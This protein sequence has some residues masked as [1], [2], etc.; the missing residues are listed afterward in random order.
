MDHKT[1]P[2][3]AE[4]VIDTV[5]KPLDIRLGGITRH[6]DELNKP[7]EKDAADQ[8]L[9][10]R[11][12]RI[13]GLPE[14]DEEHMKDTLVKLFKNRL[15]ITGIKRSDIRNVHWIGGKRTS[16]RRLIVCF[17]SKE[18]RD[19][20]YQRK[21]RTMTNPDTKNIYIDNDLTSLREK[22]FFDAR[23]LARAKKI[24][25]AWVDCGNV[26]IQRR[27][28][29]RPRTVYNLKQLAEACKK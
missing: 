8:K 29:D 3:R 13:D 1:N 26:M 2:E 23:K 15:G 22:L 28:G 5:L 6:R 20:V 10:E 18:M 7:D 17:T 21:K 24:H 12:L 4:Y 9:R 25:F 14:L 19:Q 11:N 16:T 27:E